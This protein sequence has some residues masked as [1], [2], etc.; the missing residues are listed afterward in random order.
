MSL[1]LRKKL[2]EILKIPDKDWIIF[3]AILK[4][5]EFK[6][7]EYLLQ[8]GQVCKGIYFVQEGAVRTFYV[9]EGSEIN[10]SFNFENDFLREIESLANN[11]PSLKYIQAIESSKLFFIEKRKLIDLYNDSA[12]FQ[13]LGRKILEQLTITEQKYASFLA[14]NSPKE[15]YL[16]ILKHHPALVRRVPLQ[17][18]ASYLGISRESLSRIRKRIS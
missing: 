11:Q 10:V 12:F 16:Y 2:E 6:K 4:P 1:A 14:S 15:R 13:E 3:E 18:L 8:Q 5:L 17:Y 9:K 7:N